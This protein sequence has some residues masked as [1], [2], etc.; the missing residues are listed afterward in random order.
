MDAQVLCSEFWKL[1]IR[2][3]VGFLRLISYLTLNYP[4]I[5]LYSPMS[6]YGIQSENQVHNEFLNYA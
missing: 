3:H 5:N 6:L 2:I 4:N 1:I